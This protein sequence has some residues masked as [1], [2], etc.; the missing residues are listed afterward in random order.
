MH[1]RYDS[2]ANL[3]Y[4]DTGSGWAQLPVDATVITTGYIDNSHLHNILDG[5]IG[6]TAAI[7]WSKISKSGS[8]LADLAT[9]SAGDL[10]SGT[11]LDA[12]LSTNVPTKSGTNAFTGANSFATNPLNLLVGQ[13]AFP[14]TQNPSSGA[15]TLD[16]YEEFTWNPDLSFGGATTGIT[17]S[18][19]W[20]YGIKI[21]K[22]VIFYYRFDLSSK[23]TATGYVD[24]SLPTAYAFQSNEAAAFVS[25]FANITLPS[26]YYG[27]AG[28]PYSAKQIRLLANGNAGMSLSDSAF[29]N[30]SSLIGGGFFVA[31]S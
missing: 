6:A 22:L 2:G 16:D 31:S 4:Y 9:R 27:I 1:I 30:N 23:G 13:L 21:G 11:L 5:Q 18:N 10:N 8:S 26:G 15:N 3:W 14:A 20:G 28:Y 25:Y 19:R 29:A 7:S 17:Y 12:R 24:V